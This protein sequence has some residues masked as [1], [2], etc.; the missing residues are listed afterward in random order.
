MQGA[1]GPLRA[2]RSSSAG[3]R[4]TRHEA[5]EGKR[6]PFPLEGEKENREVTEL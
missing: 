1:P 4:Q 2:T 6:G 3:G 5:A